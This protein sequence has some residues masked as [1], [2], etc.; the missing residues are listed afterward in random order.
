[1]GNYQNA[2][3][4][5]LGDRLS[6]N[7][8]GESIEENA[9]KNGQSLSREEKE[10][11]KRLN[12]DLKTRI[13]LGARVGFICSYP[14][15][16]Q[17]TLG[18]KEKNEFV[19]IGEAAHIYGAV[20]PQD[21][22]K[23]SRTPRPALSSMK[24]E[25]ITD[26]SNGI[27]LCRH[28]HRLIDAI[29]SDEEY[30]PKELYEWKD[31]AEN[32]QK[33]NLIEKNYEAISKLFEPKIQYGKINTSSFETTEWALVLYADNSGKS[34]KTDNEDFNIGEYIEWLTG[35][36]IQPKMAGV[37]KDW[38]DHYTFLNLEKISNSLAGIISF[39]ENLTVLNRGKYFG[40]LHN[41]LKKLNIEY[42]E[43]LL[44]KMQVEY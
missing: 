34:Y 33:E 41:D 28:H 20:K 39:S 12:F 15:C 11:Y 2:I 26:I 32:R 25:D 16:N 37:G 14:N 35:N 3:I 44:E 30:T 40:A 27:W 43:L 21:H 6:D 5:C 13:A 10:T 31:N 19:I 24:D 36:N 7:P 29:F 17:V 38:N 1:M 4:N 42:R 18:P 22:S 8:Y 9:Q 23:S